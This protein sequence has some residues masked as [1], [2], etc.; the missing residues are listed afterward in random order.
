[1]F[2]CLM[3]MFEEVIVCCLRE[4]GRERMCV[5]VRACVRVGG[6]CLC[7]FPNVIAKFLNFQVLNRKMEKVTR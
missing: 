4:R 6:L 7:V 1:M 5:H 3:I 2:C